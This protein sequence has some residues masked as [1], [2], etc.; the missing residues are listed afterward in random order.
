MNLTASVGKK[1]CGTAADYVAI[2]LLCAGHIGLVQAEIY[3]HVDSEGNVTYT[4]TPMRG[5]K[6]LDLAP[7]LAAP[8]S[9]AS[10]PRSEAGHADFPKVDSATQKSR[11]G[12]R[13]KILMDE[14][15]A[16][17]KLLA[18]ARQNLKEAETGPEALSGKNARH[19]E[20]IK[21]LHEQVT[22]HETNVGALKIELSGRK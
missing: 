21:S 3:K 22:L 10:R 18:E 17:E 15:A 16:E 7:P 1:S 14:L 5:A 19:G 12:A 11:D 13:H 2:A 6:K 4:S 20:K 8:S 9:S